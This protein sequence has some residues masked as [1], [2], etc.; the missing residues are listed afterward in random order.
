MKRFFNNINILAI[1]FPLIMIVPNILLDIT[2]QMSFMAKVINILVPLSIYYLLMSARRNAGATVLWLFI[3]MVMNGF[4][5]VVLYLFGESIIAI[6]MLINCVTTNTSE[7]S[8]LLSNLMLPIVIDI[9]MFI[10]IIAWAIYGAIKKLHT[11]DKFRK[12]SRKYGLIGLSTGIIFALITMLACKNYNPARQLYPLNVISNIV[13]ALHRTYQS[14]H[15]DKT[16]ADFK[17]NAVDLHANGC[18]I[19]NDSTQTFDSTE[20]Y[21]LV[22]GETSRAINW[23]LFGYDR[24]T[25][26][27]LSQRNDLITFPRAISQSNTTHKCVPMMLTHTTPLSFDSIMYRKSIIAAFNEVGYNTAV[28]SNQAKNHSYT[29]YFSEEADEVKYLEGEQHY[30][31]NLVTLLHENLAKNPKG[32]HFIILHTY[33]SHFNYKD[34]YT[35]EFSYF[36]PDNVSQANVRHRQH[37]LN[38]YD[39]AIR[40][41]DGV[42]DDIINE[43]DA[44]GTKAVM[45]YTSDHGE[46]IFD[47]DRGR[48][49]HAS[50]VPT[51]YQLHVPMIIWTSPEYDAAYPQ[52][53]ET[54]QANSSKYVAPSQTVFHTLLDISGIGTPYYDSKQSAASPDYTSPSPLYLNDYNEGVPLDESG[55]KPHDI[56]LFKNIGIL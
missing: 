30:D 47:D 17:Y 32:K 36:K 51:Y 16:S 21:V 18:A 22:I 5:I 34:R 43:L 27:R 46:D 11:S 3:F 38:A 4:Q 50:P 45:I 24:P 23:Q 19:S 10:P 7:A 33:G 48:F 8:E 9:I 41:T 25:N 29:Q 56:E 14:A 2:E 31:N 49:L 15:Y 42:L 55:I 26:P 13:S 44:L 12:L 28:Y 52:I 53:R 20:V 1:I 39:N 40:Y 6:D 37:L 54:L 35:D